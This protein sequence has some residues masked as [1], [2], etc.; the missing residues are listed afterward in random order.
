MQ[1]ILETEKVAENQRLL[2]A[3]LKE[4]RES[5]DYFFD[6]LSHG[7]ATA[8]LNAFMNCK[9]VLVFT[10][11]GK[12]GIVAQKIAATL[13]STG[14]KA[15]YLSP[16][17]AL[18]GDLGSVTSADIVVILSK[19]GESD[20]LLNLVPCIRNKGASIIAWVSRPSSRLSKAC[21]L[22]LELPL[23]KELCPFDLAPT[24][25]PSLQMLFGDVMA[26]AL[27]RLKEL[28]LAEYATNHPSGR[29]GKRIS[30][31]VSD[32]ML[33]G[34]NLPIC[35][36]QD[37]LVDQLVQLSNKRCGCLIVVDKKGCLAGIFTDGDL[38]RALQ[39]KKE[40][41]FKTTMEEI[42]TKTPKAIDPNTLAYDALRWMEADQ[43]HPITVLPVVEE[44][45]VVGVIKLHD[46]LQSGL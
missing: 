30:L 22:V 19:S 42:M 26:V 40:E 31:K 4:Q 21:D 10:G 3:L 36:P 6:G 16:I 44:R 1:E 24:T 23:N 15:L 17:N 12:S 18:H 13:V 29:I 34:Q 27:M 2:T 46:I 32:L 43:N 28:S 5:F 38:R 37:L 14:T 7:Q 33:T 39:S 41:L 45:T 9:G 25:S 35:S 20:E 11:V 8:V